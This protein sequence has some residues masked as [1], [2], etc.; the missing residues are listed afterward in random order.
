M[1][2]NFVARPR[3]PDVCDSS[4]SPG[5]LTLLTAGL[6]VQLEACEVEVLSRRILEPSLVLEACQLPDPGA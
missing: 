5:L 2:S 4:D 1:Q 3:T 6:G